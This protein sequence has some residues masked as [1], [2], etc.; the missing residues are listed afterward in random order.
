MDIEALKEGIGKIKVPRR[1]RY[2]NIRHKLE[3]ILIIGLCSTLCGG[4]DF[5]EME[6]FGGCLLLPSYYIPPC[7]F[8]AG[9]ER[10]HML[11]QEI[12]QAEHLIPRLAG[13]VCYGVCNGVIQ[14][15]YNYPDFLQFERQLRK[16]R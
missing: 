11:L 13:A 7:T 1:T 3:D 12:H 15:A 2:G 4:E 6:E 8:Y 9:H 5:A 16:I 14:A 10:V